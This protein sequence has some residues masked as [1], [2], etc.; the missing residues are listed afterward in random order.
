M[1]V[2]MPE[3]QR[4]DGSGEAKQGKGK[5]PAVALHPFA[6]AS[7]GN[8]DVGWSDQGAGTSGVVLPESLV[9]GD[10]VDGITHLSLPVTEMNLF[11]ISYQA[12]TIQRTP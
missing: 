9:R 8:E 1:A 10:T 11:L 7:S 5:C 12:L 2:G 6:R 3:L 4:Q